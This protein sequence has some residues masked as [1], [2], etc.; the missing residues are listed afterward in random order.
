MTFGALTIWQAAALLAAAGAAAAW[1]FRLKVRPPRVILPSLLLWR[2]VLDEPHQVTFWERVRR[3]A[4]FAV[5]VAIAVALAFALTRPSRSTRGGAVARGRTQIVL[6]SSLS[7]LARTKS[8]ETR[9]SRA[10]AE[11]RR[12]AAAS[13]ADVSLAT[14]ADGVIEGPTTDISLIDSAL[15]RISPAG[16]DASWRPAAGAADSIHFITDG[17]T[18]RPWSP[19][20]LRP[21]PL[22]ARPP[23][24]PV[25]THSVFEPAGNV[26]IVAFDARPSLGRDHASDAYLE[27]AN[28][29]A[30][31]QTVHLT[32]ERGRTKLLERKLEMRAGE[33]LRQI[34][35]LQRGGDATLRA[36]VEAPVDALAI[37]NEA[38]AWIERARPLRVTVVGQHTSWLA[39]LLARDPDV[40]A[41]F[42]DPSAYGQ[43]AAED[44]VIFDRWTP[45]E[46]PA[47]PSL[48]FAPPLG[49]TSEELRPVW[50]T[51]GSDPV[52]SGVDPFTLSIEKA[53]T[54]KLPNL[55]VVAQ[56]ARGTPLVYAGEAGAHRS[57]VVTFGPA[58]SNLASAPAFPVLIGNA[59]DWLGRV[60]SASAHR[61]GPM[62]FDE[63]TDDVRAPNGEPVSLTR[64]NHV[65]VG[66]L[67][68][69]GLYIAE[70]GAART[71]I[72]V[73]A[74]SREVSNLERTLLTPEQ[75]SRA[76][77]A[78]VSPRPWWMY[79]AMLAFALALAE[80]WTWQRRITV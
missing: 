44:V 59:L 58:E 73:N 6:D 18:P 54:Y 31:G 78:G 69:P 33:M 39:T 43:P 11:A 30:S 71:A 1:L 28:Y 15:D 8:G 29:A 50:T 10:I 4:S 20:V 70:G 48:S 46:P 36:R 42:V 5:T 60:S 57:V 23:A 64:F 35:P 38:V 68:A 37:D 25:V 66:V 55:R 22:A 52:V 17:A 41:T 77:A 51:A 79:A 76:V 40:Q 24:P 14:T 13:A 32:I 47:R 74:G 65:A 19:F 72:A 45:K 34:I 67:R 75:Q 80:W 9:W 27:L 12:I 62:I 61:P 16:G 56:S 53:R 3:A 63:A 49:T 21:S 2:R 26:A 7:M